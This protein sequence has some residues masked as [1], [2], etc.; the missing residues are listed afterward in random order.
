MTF[1]RQRSVL[2]AA[3]ALPKAMQ[4]AGM[5]HEGG[6][7]AWLKAKTA[8]AEPDVAGLSRGSI[9]LCMQTYHTVAPDPYRGLDTSI[10]SHHCRLT[11]QKT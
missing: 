3:E 8:N 6:V 11:A 4:C 2:V 7:E 10:P 1:H 5:S 9:V